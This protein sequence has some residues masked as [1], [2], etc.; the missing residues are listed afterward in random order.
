MIN[1]MVHRLM[2]QRRR[3][4][5]RGVTALIAMM[6][7]VLIS[8]LALGFYAMTTMSSQ[9]SS[10]DA[11]IARAYLAAESGMDF[12]R[13]Q[14]A[15]VTV[16]PSVQPADAIE[17]YYP[18]LQT[19]LNGT[20]NLENGS[21]GRDG[22]TITIPGSGTIKLDPAGNA[23]FRATI[24]DWAGEIVV[25]IE[26]FY[27][28]ASVQRNLTMD[29]SRQP[30]NSSIF[31]FAVA[32]R[33]QIVMKKGTVSS[34]AGVNPNIA[35][36][37]SALASGTSLVVTGG[38]IGGDLTLMDTASVLVSGGNVGG[39]SL[40]SVILQDHVHSTDVAPEFPTFDPTVYKHYAA[41]AYVS[42]AKTQQNILIKKNTNPKFNGNDT[43]QGLMYIESPNQVTFNGNFNLQ[44]FIVMEAGT[45]TTDSLT[46]KGNLTMSPVPNQPAFNSVRAVSGVAV[47]APNAAMV[48]TGSSGGTVKGNIVV[49]TFDFQGAADLQ[50]D[51]GTLMTLSPTSNSIVF[52]GAKSVRFTAT[53]TSNVPSE[54]VTYS[55]Y[56]QANP[57]TYQEPTQ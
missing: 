51:L 28:S 22:N 37:F 16:P 18:N 20:G 33:G 56:Y 55:Q 40:T 6:Y 3:P 2:H 19:M 39:S 23:S 26:G 1:R 46:F 50:I 42:N 12:M 34:V 17:H 25:K 32:S 10:N 52:N 44:G 41:H 53:G 48:M 13:R 15:R 49:N 9:I 5:R 21:I 38:T 57:S 14:L 27:G 43:V 45:S 47:L 30:R 31:D 24:T 7:L 35:G 4:V 29:F 54:G 8:T 11:Q 36:M